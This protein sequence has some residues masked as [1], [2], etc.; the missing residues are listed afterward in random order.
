MSNFADNNIMKDFVLISLCALTILGCSAS[1]TV[2]Q[3]DGGSDSNSGDTNKDPDDP[4]SG[5]SDMFL[6]SGGQKV[7]TSSGFTMTA[8]VGETVGVIGET[9]DGYQ[10]EAVITE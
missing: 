2:G 9:N 6:G 7:I 1:G 8:V 4:T 10:L 5:S 3:I